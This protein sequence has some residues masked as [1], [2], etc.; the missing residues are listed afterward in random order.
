MRRGSR[1]TALSLLMA[2][3]RTSL[4]DCFMQRMATTPGWQ[5]VARLSQWTRGPPPGVT[6]GSQPAP[7]SRRV[8]LPIIQNLALLAAR[9]A[10]TVTSQ[11]PVAGRALA[12]VRN[13]SLA[14]TRPGRRG[15]AARR[16]RSLRAGLGRAGPAAPSREV[17]MSPAAR[18]RIAPSVPNLIPGRP[19]EGPRRPART[20]PGG[21]SGA[22]GVQRAIWAAPNPITKPGT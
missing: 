13:A 16:A 11:G 4:M 15:V 8:A 2:G 10:A 9:L 14:L 18:L 20:A 21:P 12:W 19:P 6:V 17:R 7:T 3:T 1:V 5:V 22:Q